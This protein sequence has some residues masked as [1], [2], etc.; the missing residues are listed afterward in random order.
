[1]SATILCSFD[2][3]DLA[4][5]AAGRLRHK[6]PSIRNIEISRPYFG[7]AHD[8]MDFFPAGKT[9]VSA[10]MAGMAAGMADG[11]GAAGLAA[12]NL[13][14]MSG[15]P[16]AAVPVYLGAAGSEQTDRHSSDYIPRSVTLRITCESGLRDRVEARLINLGALK[17]RSFDDGSAR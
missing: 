6:L 3:V 8:S 1:M 2:D 10:G 15:M 16:G 5:I 11:S 4:E 9:G 13:A 7:E 17:I 12:G 14:G